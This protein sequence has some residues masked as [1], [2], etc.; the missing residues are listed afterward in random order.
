[1]TTTATPTPTTTD[2]PVEGA[3]VVIEAPTAEAALAD[4][5][6]QLGPSA[7]VVEVRKVHRGGLGGFFAREIVQLHARPGEAVDP[8]P[9]GT[10]SAPAAPVARAASTPP[11]AVPADTASSEAASSD[12]AGRPAA[13]RHPADRLL[14]DEEGSGL[15]DFATYLR[16]QLDGPAPAVAPA[17][18]V[19]AADA[20]RA[21][22]ALLER[23]TAAARAAR[24]ED[25]GGVVDPTTG[26]TS[27][28]AMPEPTG[29]PAAPDDVAPAVGRSSA[30]D[31]RATTAA[32]DEPVDRD[33]VAT[34]PSS[35]T[36]ELVTEPPASVEAGP[37]WSVAALVKLGLPSA[38]VR[39]LEVAAPHDD[40]AWTAALAGALRSLCRP[41]PTGRS[42]LVG[43][44]ARAAA[45][46]TKAT[47]TPVHQPIR[48]RAQ[49]VAAAVGGG[50]AARA[51]LER[52]ASGRWLHLVVGGS[53]WRDLLELDP[54]AVSWATPGDLP[55]AVRLA[56]ELGLVLGSGPLPGGVGRARPLEIALALR[57]LLPQVRA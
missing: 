10:P 28:D 17:S 21:R 57:G 24:G 50:A 27:S 3:T 33:A 1:M 36:G 40:V 35:A 49:V 32:T 5:H 6:A 39:E 2:A 52:A 13:H 9:A 29:A 51:W 19:S 20:E 44:R 7:R 12:A 15:V 53:G 23:V 26:R 16:D 48:S 22:R 42:L 34:R 41:L 47:L 31:H 56:A 30:V 8:D 55:E 37:A 11:A 43:P 25:T 4:L 14:D 38:L 18:V 54:L 45:S 46:A